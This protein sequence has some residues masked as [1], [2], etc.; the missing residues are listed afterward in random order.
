MLEPR[1][2]LDLAEKAFAANHRA[3]FG[4]QDLDGDLAGVLEVFGEVDGGHAA[5]AEL[6]LDAIAVGKGGSE[7]V[8]AIQAGNAS[9]S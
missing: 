1:G 4:M 9:M 6:P 7:A 3:E 2:G 8:E 5:L